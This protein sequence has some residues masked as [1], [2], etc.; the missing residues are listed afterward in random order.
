MKICRPWIT[1]N[2]V[3]IYAKDRGLKAFCWDLTENEH[4]DYMEKKQKNK[5]NDE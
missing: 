4:K 3:I 5:I 1:V 2:G